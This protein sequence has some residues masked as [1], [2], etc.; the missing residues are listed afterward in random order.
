MEEITAEVVSREEMV[1]YDDPSL[2]DL[3]KYTIEELYTKLNEELMNIRTDFGTDIP[4]HERKVIFLYLSELYRRSVPWPDLLDWWEYDV[5]RCEC[6]SYHCELTALIERVDKFTVHKIMR[7]DEIRDH[8]G[9]CARCHRKGSMLSK[10]DSI[11][12][13]EKTVASQLHEI[14]YYVKTYVKMELEKLRKIKRIQL[15]SL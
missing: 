8:S 1:M 11:R 7:P 14:L 6:P 15:D 13:H 10:E 9:C 3:K 5:V 4:S 2:N 12:V